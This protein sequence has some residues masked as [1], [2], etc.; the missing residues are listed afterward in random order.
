[1]NARIAA[2]VVAVASIA[3]VVV[4]LANGAPPRRD[5]ELAHR[6]ASHVHRHVANAACNHAHHVHPS[7]V[8]QACLRAERTLAS[9]SG[10]TARDTMQLTDEP[11]NWFRSDRT[12]SPVT[13]LP[14][15]GRV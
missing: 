3:A 15:G 10:D 4:G 13:I 7:P 5:A 8:H 9:A 6:H 12:G 14:V 2:A 1:M 11:G